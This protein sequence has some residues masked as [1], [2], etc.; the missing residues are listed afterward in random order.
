MFG[1][2]LAAVY[3][4]LGDSPL[5]KHPS[6]GQ[7]GTGTP[8]PV[9]P[10]FSIL[11]GALVSVLIDGCYSRRLVTNTVVEK[12]SFKLL[13]TDVSYPVQADHISNSSSLDPTTQG[14]AI[15]VEGREELLRLHARIA[16][17]AMRMTCRELAGVALRISTAMR[18]TSQ[19]PLQETLTTLRC[20]SLNFE[21][22]EAVVQEIRPVDVMEEAQILHAAFALPGWNQPTTWAPFHSPPHITALLTTHPKPQV[23]QEGRRWSR[24]GP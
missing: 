2:V 3:H 5:D 24:L 16:F 11:K 1:S 17:R 8:E 6:V 9:T 22:L 23:T 13:L 15:S 14:Q 21:A 19:A 12:D 18:F 20:D 4:Q 7:Y 10:P